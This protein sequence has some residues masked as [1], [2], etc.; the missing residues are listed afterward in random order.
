MTGGKTIVHCIAGVSRSVS[1]CAAYLMTNVKSENRIWGTGNM[2]S[3]EAVK[4]IQKR[5]RCA[6]P[7]PG[8]TKQ[9][10][11]FEKELAKKSVTNTWNIPPEGL[12]ALESMDKIIEE[13]KSR[14]S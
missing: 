4:Y 5:R 13:L 3:E 14:N 9:L 10:S 1:L 11:L 7:N 12:E 2:G 6:N 8:F